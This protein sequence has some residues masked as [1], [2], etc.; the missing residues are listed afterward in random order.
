M[1][2][3]GFMVDL[4]LLNIRRARRFGYLQKETELD[5]YKQT[6]EKGRFKYHP[7]FLKSYIKI[8]KE[9]I[10]KHDVDAPVN[11][12]REINLYYYLFKDILEYLD[13]NFTLERELNYGYKIIREIDNYLSLNSKLIDF[14]K[15]SA[16]NLELLFTHELEL[17]EYLDLTEEPFY[18][19]IYENTPNKSPSKP[20]KSK[21]GLGDFFFVTSSS[22]SYDVTIHPT[23]LYGD[24]ADND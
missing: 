2:H 3:G 1:E 8:L 5:M 19:K 20:P 13:L 18:K 12:W 21:R 7:R 11:G 24:Y 4:V 16:T 23:E 6:V 9:T 14:R 15:I 22:T 17:L 10:N